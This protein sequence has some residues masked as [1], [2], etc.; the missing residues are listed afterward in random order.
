[1]TEEP[2]NEVPSASLDRQGPRDGPLDPLVRKLQ[3]ALLRFARGLVHSE[4][5]AEEVVQETWAAVLER[6]GEFRGE[7]SL[8]TWIYGILAKRAYSRAKAEGRSIPFSAL[9]PGDDGGEGL[10]D[11]RGRWLSEQAPRPWPSPEDAASS[12]ESLRLLEEGL[13]KLPAA[14]RT[15][16]V[17]RDVEGL[18]AEEACNILGVSET[19]QRVLLHRGRCALRSLLAAHWRGP[20]EP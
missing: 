9:E 13:A 10:F 15:I 19:N 1:M 18:S 8:K 6:I 3:P 4:S 11:G 7:S 14:Q 20:E 17:L 5:I 16:V 12:R 2:T